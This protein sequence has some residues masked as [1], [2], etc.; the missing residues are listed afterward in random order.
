[1]DSKVG[2]AAAVGFI[3]GYVISGFV[4]V[5]I[6]DKPSYQI[7]KANGFVKS[8]ETLGECQSESHYGTCTR[9]DEK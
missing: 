9:S 8:Y 7:V 2:A 1:M 3:L 5:A 4:M 6:Q